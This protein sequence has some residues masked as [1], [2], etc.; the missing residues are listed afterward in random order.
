M[1]N[2]IIIG[3]LALSLCAPF[4]AWY[5]AN[6]AKGKHI[7]EHIAIQKRLLIVCVIGVLL[8]EGLIRVS[9]GSGSL[10]QY[11][12][13]V[14]TTFFKTLL[15]AHII[16]AVITYVLWIYLVFKSNKSYKKALLPGSFSKNHKKM[17]LIV[18][19]GLFYTG[20]TALMV[21]IMA[22]VL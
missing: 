22:F 6:L 12:P 5:G 18:I 17:G 10:V 13:Y 1:G 2:F 19:A 8:L 14:Q 11:G 9:G 15:I 7:K 4:I 20:I 21:C 3:M 16:G